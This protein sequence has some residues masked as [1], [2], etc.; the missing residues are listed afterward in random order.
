MSSSTRSRAAKDSH[1]ETLGERD[2]T[3]QTY[4]RHARAFSPRATRTP[5]TCSRRWRAWGTTTP[6]PPRTSSSAA[7]TKTDRGGPE[8][9]CGLGRALSGGSQPSSPTCVGR[10]AS[11]QRRRPDKPHAARRRSLRCKRR[12]HV[13][14]YGNRLLP[15]LAE[16][17]TLT[18]GR[19]GPEWLG[20]AK[21]GPAG[22]ECEPAPAEPGPNLALET[23]ESRG[24][25]PT[26]CFS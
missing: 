3:K 13:A 8:V 15:A 17:I 11:V 2:L 9:C 14:Q 4:R 20:P 21:E 26:F 25:A 18:K 16:K 23:I 12:G 10:K 6:R 19:S 24:H 5:R 1:Q 22:T 7:A